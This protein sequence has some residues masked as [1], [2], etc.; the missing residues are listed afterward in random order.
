MGLLIELLAR[1]V[2][3]HFRKEIFHNLKGEIGEEHCERA[4]AG[5]LPLCP[6]IL[7]RVLEQPEQSFYICSAARTKIKKV[8]ALVDLLWDSGDGLARKRWANRSYGFL[9]ETCLRLIRSEVDEEYAAAFHDFTKRLFVTQSWAVPC[10]NEE[11]FWRRNSSGQRLWLALRYPVRLRE[12]LALE[13][14]APA[15]SVDFLG[16]YLETMMKDEPFKE[17]KARG[18]KQQRW[19]HRWRLVSDIGGR[20]EDEYYFDMMPGRPV[21]LREGLGL[22]VDFAALDAVDIGAQLEEIWQEEEEQDEE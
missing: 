11:Q 6:I 8:K 3:Q 22:D 5:Q 21:E 7:E 2:V 1:V 16:I 18:S 9:H 14:V 13:D 4:L 20:V 17:A 10:I 15:G 12:G 19:L